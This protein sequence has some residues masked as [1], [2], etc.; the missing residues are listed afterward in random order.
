MM[1]KKDD[2]IVGK[3]T[4]IAKF[5]IFLTFDSGYTGMVHISEM[6][7]NYVNDI[8]EYISIGDEIEVR[9]LGVDNKMQRLQLSM[10]DV[11]DIK[12]TNKNAKIKETPHGFATL[13]KNLPH[14]IDK[15]MKNAKNI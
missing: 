10:K 8:N 2:I 13:R 3:V 5:G 15:K 6:S 4:G 14:W 7:Y 11:S 1:Y 12:I 9:I